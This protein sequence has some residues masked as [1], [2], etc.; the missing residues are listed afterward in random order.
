MDDGPSGLVPGGLLKLAAERAR[1][2]GSEVG[3]PL[4]A[5]MSS[6]REIWVIDLIR[7]DSG[8]PGAPG[9]SA[10]RGD[11]TARGGPCR[12]MLPPLGLVE[13]M[14]TDNRSG[15]AVCGSWSALLAP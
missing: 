9:G 2:A 14:P 8:S 11:S 13:A 12:P 1:P 5:P 3:G 6:P 15:R 4:L 10:T 7:S